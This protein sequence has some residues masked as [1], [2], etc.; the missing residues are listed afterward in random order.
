MENGLALL[1]ADTLGPRHTRA[2][3]SR[4]L[5]GFLAVLVL[6]RDLLGNFLCDVL[7]S[8]LLLLFRQCSLRVNLKELKIYI[9]I[10]DKMTRVIALEKYT[11]ISYIHP[12]S[13]GSVVC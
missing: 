4:V 11:C 8:E 13:V 12:S 10:W 3:A 1:G 6:L 7:L 2:L 9:Y 5:E